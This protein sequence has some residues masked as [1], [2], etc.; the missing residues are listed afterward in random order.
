ML[1][2]FFYYYHLFNHNTSKVPF[3]LLKKIEITNAK[4]LDWQ[5]NG[6]LDE[7]NYTDGANLMPKSQ[8][9]YFVY[10]E[11]RERDILFLNN[12]SLAYESKY[13]QLLDCTSSLSHVP[14]NQ[15]DKFLCETIHFSYGI[16]RKQ[17]S[18]CD[19]KKRTFV[20]FSFKDQLM[21]LLVFIQ[22]M[23]DTIHWELVF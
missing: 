23:M 13:R 10:D 3:F 16:I 5:L 21:M 11:E 7:S 17:V 22:Q 15:S 9:Y 18:F 8:S 20:E 4:V 6:D 19:H 2:Q 12:V 14:T 1:L